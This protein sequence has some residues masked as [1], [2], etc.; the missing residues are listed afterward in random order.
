MLGPCDERNL[1]FALQVAPPAFSA[2]TRALAAKA[3]FL[4]TDREAN[5]A[6]L[7]QDLSRFPLSSTSSVSSR[8]TASVFFDSSIPERIRKDVRFAVQCAATLGS[9]NSELVA[10]ANAVDLLTSVDININDVSLLGFA[11]ACRLLSTLEKDPK[12][13]VFEA[14]LRYIKSRLNKW[15]AA[16]ASE[17]TKLEYQM[18]ETVPIAP[19]QKLAMDN[20]K[21]R[22]SDGSNGTGYESMSA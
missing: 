18:Q 10:M 16:L 4:E 9:L 20:A 6:K 12:S 15:G 19:A 1:E 14:C 11:A 7:S 13:G 8:A 3:I 22:L 5:I 17:D 2:Y 21:R